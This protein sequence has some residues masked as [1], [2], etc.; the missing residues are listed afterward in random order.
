MERVKAKKKPLKATELRD[1]LKAKYQPPEWVLLNEVRAGTGAYANRSADCMALSTWPSRGILLYGFELKS[2]RADVKKEL[3][4]PAKAQELS[5]YCDRWY[6]V[7]GR[8]DL[9]QESELPKTWGLM[10][11]HGTG[12]RIKKEAPE[13]KAKKWDRLFAASMIRN[14]FQNNLGDEERNE[15]YRRGFKAGEE[16]RQLTAYQAEKELKA[17]KAKVEQ[18][19]RLTGVSALGDRWA[20]EFK[21]KEDA[22]KFRAIMQ[23]GV[24]K[25][26][27][28]ISRLVTELDSLS[29]DMKRKLIQGGV[30]KEEIT[31]DDPCPHPKRHGRHELYAHYPQGKHG[32]K[33]KRPV[34]CRA[35]GAKGVV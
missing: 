19:E 21:V 12:L 29:R 18:F 2:S 24:G 17:L 15:N 27:E 32:P 30:V 10:V 14:A 22:D 25:Y 5:M 3:S 7:V 23:S 31:L 16:S 35:C 4:D 33:G 9:I 26:F 20:H 28:R 11:P 34:F 13:R 8:A 1:R 6:L